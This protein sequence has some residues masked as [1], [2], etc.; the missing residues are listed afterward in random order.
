[1]AGGKVEET[2]VSAIQKFYEFVFGM[3]ANTGEKPS[4]IPITR[5]EK[6]ELMSQADMVYTVVKPDTNQILGID[7]FETPFASAMRIRQLDM[8]LSRIA[9]CAAGEA[10]FHNSEITQRT[11]VNGMFRILEA[12]VV[13]DVSAL[14]VSFEWDPFARIKRLLR[15]TKWFP[16][17]QRTVTIDCRV[18][19]PYIKVQLPHN[20]HHVQFS[21]KHL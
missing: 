5:T 9:E 3:Q 7:A 20:R 2:E 16:V 18:L 19:Y 8:S 10:L 17:K 13:S 21:T 15:I 12:K 14:N 1:M 4:F 11:L 6:V